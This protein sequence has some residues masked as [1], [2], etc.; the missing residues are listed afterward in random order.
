MGDELD[1]L[2]PTDTGIS[3]RTKDSWLADHGLSRQLS[4]GNGSGN[5]SGNAVVTGKR[6]LG[7]KGMVQEHIPASPDTGNVQPCSGLP[8]LQTAQLLPKALGKGLP[9]K[10]PGLGRDAALPPEFCLFHLSTLQK[11]D[12]FLILVQH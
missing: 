3:C 6:L 4:P 11:W 1:V 2:R 10:G 7:A 5:G 8:L 9:R 12:C